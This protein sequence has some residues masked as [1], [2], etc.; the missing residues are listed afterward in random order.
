MSPILEID[1]IVSLPWGW[2]FFSISLFYIVCHC[3]YNVFFHP[4]AKYPGPLLAK[5]T[6]LRATYHPWKG[7]VHLDSWRCHHI[8]GPVF[9][10]APGKLV[11]STPAAMRDIYSVT[12]NVTKDPAYEVLGQNK[13]NLVSVV[14]KEEHLR[15]RKLVT[16][17]FSF[18]NIKAFEPRM[19]VYVQKFIDDLS[20]PQPQPL[21]TGWT[22]SIDVA[23]WCSY[24]TFDVMTEFL[25]GTKYDLLRDPTWREVVHAIES[26]NVRLYVLAHLP[27]LYVGRF[28]KW[29]FPAATRGSRGFLRFVKQLLID[30]SH[31]QQDS[32][33]RAF[34]CLT[35]AVGKDGRPTMS[36]KQTF[37]EAVMLVTAAQDTT[38]VTLRAILFYLSRNPHAYAKLAHEIRTAF[39]QN[40]AI[41]ADD[42]LKAC[43]YL[44]SCVLE[45]MRMS[46]AITGTAM[47]R[48]VSA[49][50]QVID[51]EHI[52]A[53]YKVATGIYAVHHNEKYF[54]RPFEF[55]PERWIA[56]EH[57][58][59]EQLDQRLKMWFPFSAGP[60]ACIGKAFAL[61]LISITIA[62]VVREYDFRVADG[63]EGA[64]GGG[65]PFGETGRTNPGE[66][67]LKDYIVSTGEGPVLQF[68][69][70][71]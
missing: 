41:C 56:D 33:I 48:H 1:T 60:R 22:K 50:G 59:Q 23:D 58:S 24:L 70:R 55:I 27:L 16:S 9:R 62:S 18:A 14:D 54:P 19:L 5:I 13:L 65:H 30:Q 21:S 39:A 28:D 63:P 71:M 53:G 45:S 69:T 12:S 35:G 42:K 44:N 37:S 26:T 66:Y 25:F 7:D 36:T 68:R 49:G 57:T 4:L 6:I 11:F 17:S 3:V 52:P 40:E 20:Q 32:H 64:V 61:T 51:G 43:V 34:S 47:F 15:R 46:P 10:Y 29:M 31:C 8:Y 2:T 38:S 67:Q